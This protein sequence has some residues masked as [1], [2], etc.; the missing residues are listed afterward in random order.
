MFRAGR[1]VRGMSQ[2][3]LAPFGQVLIALAE[4]GEAYVRTAI[5]ENGARQ[6]PGTISRCSPTGYAM[7]TPIRS[8][9]AADDVTVRW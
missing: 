5:E 8:I 1:R 2:A 3:A 4:S 7:V 6:I 9:G